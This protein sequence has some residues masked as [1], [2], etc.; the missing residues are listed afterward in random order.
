MD[1]EYKG[2]DVGYPVCKHCRSDNIIVVAAAHWD[3]ENQEWKVSTTYDD[4]H[5]IACDG[6]TSTIWIKTED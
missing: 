6:E 5:C 3:T 1:E 4:Y 2:F